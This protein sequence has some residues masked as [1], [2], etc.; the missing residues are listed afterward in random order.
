MPVVSHGQHNVQQVSQCATVYPAYPVAHP[1]SSRPPAPSHSRT[2]YAY[3][4]PHTY[5]YGMP[6]VTAPHGV[7]G[8]G[9]R[10]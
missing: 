7:P 3:A 2:L 10:P 9:A 6:M 8:R 5:P 4:Y 1:A